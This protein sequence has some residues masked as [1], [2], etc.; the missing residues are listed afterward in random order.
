MIKGMERARGVV[1][2]N[3]RTRAWIHLLLLDCYHRHARARWRLLSAAMAATPFL[4]SKP[5]GSSCLA[6]SL[7]IAHL[8]L[9]QTRRMGSRLNITDR[10]PAKR[11]SF[12]LARRSSGPLGFSYPLEAASGTPQF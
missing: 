11:S 8:D 3:N 2:R 1:A 5:K 10:Q 12:M 4:I 7:H 9:I 6:R